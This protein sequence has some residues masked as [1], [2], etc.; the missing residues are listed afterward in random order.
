MAVP[1]W[2]V[3]CNKP[4]MDKDRINKGQLYFEREKKLNLNFEV[5]FK[6][7]FSFRDQLLNIKRVIHIV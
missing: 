3:D 2:A 4:Q 5:K 1:S 7:D 6:L